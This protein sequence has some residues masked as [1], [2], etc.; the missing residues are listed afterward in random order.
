MYII[1]LGAPGAGKGT[2]A[3]T[4]ARE[5][6]LTHLA[7]GDLYRQAVAQGTELGK[8]AKYYMDQGELSPDELTIDM[9]MERISASDCKEGVIFDGFP[10]TLRQ[11]Q[12]LDEMLGKQN[13]E[14]DRTVYIKVPEEELFKRLSGRWVC[15]GC[16]TPYHTINSQPK[17]TGKCDRCG[18]ELYQRAD[19]KPDT[20][21]RRLEV[22]FQNTAPLIDYYTRVGK[23][24]E[25]DGTG[26]VDEVSKR[27]ILALH[28]SSVTSNR[29]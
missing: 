17:V 25:V 12:A 3:A 27:I 20:I 23:L 29:R 22:Y 26:E 16:Q 7:T 14:I 11:A 6:N 2:Q 4:V 13:Q 10:R 21:K 5:L 1:L 19:D 18:G 24:I 9:I 28:E 15:R 8:K